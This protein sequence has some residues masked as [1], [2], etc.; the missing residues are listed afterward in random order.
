ML[1]LMKTAHVVPE[2][3]AVLVYQGQGGQFFGVAPNLASVRTLFNPLLALRTS[4]E[5]AIA[6]C[7]WR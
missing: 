7:P 1:S 2:K 3:R 4:V 6:F 5:V